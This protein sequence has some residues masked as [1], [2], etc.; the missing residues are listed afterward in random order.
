[1]RRAWQTE[2]VLAEV[3][4]LGLLA[5]LALIVNLTGPTAAEGYIRMLRQEADSAQYVVAWVQAQGAT[6]YGLE[7]SAAGELLVASETVDPQVADTV[8][9]P[10]EEERDGTFCV[11]A[12]AR[13]GN[14]ERVSDPA[15][16]TT[17]LPE[18]L[19]T[20]PP[21][22]GIDVSPVGDEV[23]AIDSVTIYPRELEL[24]VGEE[25]ELRAVAWIGETPVVCGDLTSGRRGWIEIADPEAGDLAFPSPAGFL[26]DAACG[27][28][29]SSLDESVVT[30][31]PAPPT[32]ITDPEVTEINVQ[33]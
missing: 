20:P 5:G 21:P 25:A 15:C 2:V 26:E 30:V 32:V 11:V 8:W 23:A 24:V 7:V 6:H 33:A 3:V 28:E 29:W 14:R 4:A 16:A 18:A 1:M 10:L 13:R 22:G 17:T 19:V 9:V 27:L 31:E 12:I